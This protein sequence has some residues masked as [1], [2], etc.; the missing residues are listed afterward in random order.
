MC[1][2]RLVS[3]RQ[4]YLFKAVFWASGQLSVMTIKITVSERGYC[5]QKVISFKKKP[6]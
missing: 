2:R 4:Q 3:Y 1:H 6:S 5:H